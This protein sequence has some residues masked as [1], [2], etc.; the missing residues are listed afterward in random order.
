MRVDKA[1]CIGIRKYENESDPSKNR[2]TV[3]FAYQNKP[4]VEGLAVLTFSVFDNNRSIN[5]KDIAV[6]KFYSI[7]YHRD[8]KYFVIDDI[9]VEAD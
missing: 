4:A 7:V 6:S 8:E 1:Q 2:R 3:Y 5:I 9:R